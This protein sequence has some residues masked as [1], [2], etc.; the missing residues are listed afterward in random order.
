M[1][2]DYDSVTD[3]HELIRKIN[4]TFYE[5]L[6]ANILYIEELSDRIYVAYIVG[7]RDA[8][9]HLVRVFDY[10]ILS[11]SG[12]RNVQQQLIN[13]IDDLQRGLL[14]TF[15]KIL[16]LELKS[17]SKIIHKNNRAAMEYQVA[18]E[19][20]RLRIMSKDSTPGDRIDG[21]VKLMDYLSEMRK[22]L[23]EPARS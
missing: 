10:D 22:K 3:L 23:Y 2:L 17:L 21:Y 18:Q 7:L 4:I 8:Y 12:K 20:S 16:A 11:L 6:N 14:D 15:R 9:S 1:D 13:Y 19:A 5:R